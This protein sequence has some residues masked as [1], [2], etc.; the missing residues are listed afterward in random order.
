MLTANARSASRFRRPEMIDRL[1]SF[2]VR[3]PWLALPLLALPA[4]LPY[5]LTGF[6]ETS[7]GHLHLLRL[8]LLDGYIEQGWFYPRWIP[9]LVLG[10]G[11][12][13]LNFYAP[14]SYYVAEALHL[15]GFGY[16]QALALA[17][18]MFIVLAGLGMYLL[19]GEIFGSSRRAAR[20]I[21]ATAY[22]YAPYLLANSFV[23]GAIAE[24]GAQALLP[25]VFWTTHRLLMRGQPR[26]DVVPA[27][28]AIA[29]LA[30]T[31][32]ITLL[33][34][35]LVWLAYVLV[36]WWQ[37]GHR[38][39]S[40][41]GAGAAA[42]LAMLLSAFFWL[43]MAVERA[44]L[45]NA[46]YEIS[47]RFLPE[48]VWTLGNFLDPNFFYK[49]GYDVPYRL[50]LVQ[51][52][53][54]LAGFI[55]ARRKDAVW[56]FY[57]GLAL[58]IGLAIAQWTL[59]IWLNVKV[60]L[61]VQ[62]PWR[63]LSILSV[64]LALFTGA[65]VL[66]LRHWAARLVVTL[67]LLAL[68]IIAQRPTPSW[69]TSMTLDS[70]AIVPA[71][72]AHFEADSGALG[73]SNSSEFL[74][75]WVKST[76]FLGA[77]QTAPSTEQVRLQAANALDLS[78]QA[79]GD[80]G[81]LR[82]NTIYYPGWTAMLDGQV[83]LQTY[84]STDLGLLTVDMP[85]G[86]HTLILRWEGTLLARVASALS[87]IALLGAAVWCLLL[88]PKHPLA[89]PLLILLALGALAVFSHP[90]TGAVV[91]PSAS[92]ESD[93]I[94]LLGY[95]LAPDG[96]Q[97][98]LVRPF[99]YTK[100]PAPEDLQV[101]WQLLDQNGQVLTQVEGKPYYGT[102][103][104]ADWPPGTVARDAYRLPLPSGQFSASY[105]LAAQIDSRDGGPAATPVVVGRVEMPGMQG[106]EPDPAASTDVRFG[107]SIALRGYGLLVNGNPV[108]LAQTPPPSV[109]PGDK[110]EFLLYW[111]G[112]GQ[113][114]KDYH[115]FLHL[116][117]QSG[118]ALAKRD[119]SAGSIYATSMTWD[120]TRGQP[121]RY[122]IIVPP[123][124]PGGLYSAAVGL[125]DHQTFERLPV[126]A[127]RSGEDS[128][129]FQLPPV[130]V[131]GQGADMPQHVLPARFGDIARLEGYTLKAPAQVHPG[132]ELRLTLYYEAEKNSGQNLTRFVQL[133]NPGL[134]MAAQKDSIP[135]EG[136]NPTWSWVPG[137]QI[138]EE[139]TL[140]VA[141]DARPGQ[142]TLAVGLYD[143]QNGGARVP[144]LD[145]AGHPL[146]DSRVI[147]TELD[148][149]PAQ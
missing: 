44:Y 58:A 122:R 22:M 141:P 112:N 7:D 129:Y 93:S 126:R 132:D 25:W 103:S 140:S 52:G 80:G 101:R 68:I 13:L 19:A 31:H 99:W 136:Q 149:G 39:D 143:A 148:V 57:G 20:L 87:L 4:V 28:L 2:A 61:T 111:Q 92:V 113:I 47:A 62:F 12:P 120:T 64:P 42:V 5:W 48:N 90:A 108:S 73:T 133:H 49:Y 106:T 78:L 54:A 38:R 127:G 102:T 53:L 37:G 147:L 105:Q 14:A 6:P 137:E 89:V 3:H 65:V 30:V 81:P 76:H 109:R 11:Y 123:N 98:L 91:A 121:D 60:L 85:S 69:V 117:D 83:R 35:P 18:A 134:G 55:L 86:T 66:P 131:L 82:I 74:P 8:A 116:L 46:A 41:L 135:Q 145:E 21:A 146:P 88:R 9:A 26:R 34:L 71:A 118:N 67:G 36:L 75:G 51:F 72:A 138:R 125:Y 24:V 33:F 15:L 40:L 144:A 63:L 95:Q 50:G 107:E 17:F 128:S 94:Q 29:G 77:A 27:A 16:Q 23:R 43:P 56:L 142:Y 32:N 84:P 119:Q 70:V 139:V 10:R 104:A 1:A 45:S 130:K 96:E 59:P 115:G 79:S 114:D 110:L 100:Q 97:H 124:S